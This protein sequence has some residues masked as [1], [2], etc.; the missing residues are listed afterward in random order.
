MRK[1][2]NAAAEAMPSYATFLQGFAA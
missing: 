2:I 1:A